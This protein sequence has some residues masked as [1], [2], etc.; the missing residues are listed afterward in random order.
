MFFQGIS[1]GGDGHRRQMVLTQVWGTVDFPQEMSVYTGRLMRG[2]QVKRPW[3]ILVKS[4]KF[5]EALRREKLGT[6]GLQEV[7]YVKLRV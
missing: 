1:A 4:V 3:E 5:S 7:H 2:E 6:W